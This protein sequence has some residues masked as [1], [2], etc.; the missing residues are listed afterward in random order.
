VR[1][2]VRPGFDAAVRTSGQPIRVAVVKT[3]RFLQEIEYRQLLSH[4]GLHFEKLHGFID[5]ETG[6][7]L[8]SIRI[9]GAAR[10]LVC[11]NDGPSL[12][13]V[14]LRARHDDAYRGNR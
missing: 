1:I 11:L 8:Y 4:P 12:I 5:P 3:L 6:N 13:L 14:T 10:A 7:Q 9:S 2:E